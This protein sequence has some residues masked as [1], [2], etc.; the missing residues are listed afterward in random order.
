MFYFRKKSPKGQDDRAIH[1][2]HFKNIPMADMEL[3]L[4]SAGSPTFSK[5]RC[6]HIQIFFVYRTQPYSSIQLALC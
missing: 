6:D 2:K 5:K 4:V 1:V 3:V